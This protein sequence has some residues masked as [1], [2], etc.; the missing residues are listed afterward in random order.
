MTAAKGVNITTLDTKPVDYP[1]VAQV[2]GRLRVWFDSYEAS[3]LAS[4][5]T[6]AVARL[7]KG[8]RLYDVQIHH[9]DLG[10][11]AG[12]LEVGD[13]GD[14]DRFIAAFATGSAGVRSMHA[15]GVIDNVGY[16]MPAE[17]DI[18]ITTAGASVTGTIK[19]V[20]IYA[21]D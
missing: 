6:I 13:S 12:T 10:T 4:G 14:P 2:S 18:L 21:I 5:S 8:S 1:D 19:S 15:N 7:P 9:D 16:Q 17:T 3:G 20:V 11:A